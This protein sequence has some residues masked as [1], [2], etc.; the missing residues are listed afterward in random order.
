MRAAPQWLTARCRWGTWGAY[1]VLLSV[2]LL[3]PASERPPELGPYREWVQK[4]KQAVTTVLHVGCY[5]VMSILWC[6]AC[7][8]AS[9]ATLTSSTLVA[10]AHGM[11]TEFLQGFVPGRYC[12]GLDMLA[13]LGGGLLGAALS[14]QIFPGGALRE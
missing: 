4:H 2:L 10:A 14:R 7:R 1:V 13:D 11:A 6:W 12:D 3:R 5:A 8:R 9:L